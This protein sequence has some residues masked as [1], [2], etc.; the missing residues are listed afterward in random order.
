MTLSEGFRVNVWASEP[1]IAY[2][3]VSDGEHD[4]EWV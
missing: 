1:M 2:L 3:M 4:L